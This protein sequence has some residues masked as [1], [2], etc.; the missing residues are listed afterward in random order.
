MRETLERHRPLVVCETHGT[1]KK[2]TEVLR[3][4]GYATEVVEPE[5]EDPWNGQ[6]VARPAAQPISRR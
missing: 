3:G 4:H 2:V 5:S 1:L 6:V